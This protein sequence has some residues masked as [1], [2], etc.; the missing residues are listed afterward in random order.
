MELTV[1]E[2][3]FEDTVARRLLRGDD[4]KDQTGIASRV[5]TD[6]PL[7]ISHEGWLRLPLKLPP[8]RQPDFEESYRAY[9]LD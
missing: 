6:R 1:R 9:S 7:S 3:A 4:A 5:L 2:A 8:P